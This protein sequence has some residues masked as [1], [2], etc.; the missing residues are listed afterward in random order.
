MHVTPHSEISVP[1]LDSE[2]RNQKSEKGTVVSFADIELDSH[3]MVIWLPTKK[4]LKARFLVNQAMK[5]DSLSLQE[6]QP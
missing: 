6:L 4:L 3:N 2:S 1:R 5:C